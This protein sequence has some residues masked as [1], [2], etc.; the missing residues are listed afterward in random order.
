LNKRA[1]R[2]CGGLQSDTAIDYAIRVIDIHFQAFC[3]KTKSR[4]LCRALGF[5]AFAANRALINRA[6]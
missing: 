4:R 6:Y 1:D 2:A 3:V 5:R